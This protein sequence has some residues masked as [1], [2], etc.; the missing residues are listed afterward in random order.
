[1]STDERQPTSLGADLLGVLVQGVA[2]F[3]AAVIVHKTAQA[4]YGSRGVLP[5]MLPAA[6]GPRPRRPKRTARPARTARVSRLKPVAVIDTT[7]TVIEDR[8]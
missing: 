7:A 5:A 6:R 8:S 4:L 2:I 1:M 3:G